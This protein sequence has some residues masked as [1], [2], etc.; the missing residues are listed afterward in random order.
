VKLKVI[1]VRP[2]KEICSSGSLGYHIN[3]SSRKQKKNGFVLLNSGLVLY[4]TYKEIHNEWGHFVR[5]S[6][7]PTTSL[8]W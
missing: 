8:L 5:N 3:C 4:R 7:W 6:S 1:A 2:N